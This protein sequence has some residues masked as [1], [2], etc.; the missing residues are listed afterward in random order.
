[1]IDDIVS[2]PYTFFHV[3]LEEIKNFFVELMIFVSYLEELSKSYCSEP[4]VCHLAIDIYICTG[5]N[6]TH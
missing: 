1:M 6:P 2:S 5:R 4:C 3:P